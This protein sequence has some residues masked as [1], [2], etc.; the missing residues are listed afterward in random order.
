MS[1][2]RRAATGGEG[3]RVVGVKRDGRARMPEASRTAVTGIFYLSRLSWKE[4]WGVEGV[5]GGEGRR[6]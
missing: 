6:G 4:V 3:R 2:W 1:W 5:A